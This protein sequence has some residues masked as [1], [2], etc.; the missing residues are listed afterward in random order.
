[1]KKIIFALLVGSFWLLA[2]SVC[3]AAPASNGVYFEGNFGYGKVDEKLVPSGEIGWM[4][5]NDNTGFSWNADVGYKFSPSWAIE[6]G[7]NSL[8]NEKFSTNFFSEVAEGTDNYFID[9]AL[10][11]IIPF[12]S[13]LS[14]FAKAGAAYVN[15][16]LTPAPFVFV[17]HSGSNSGYSPLVGLGIGYAITPNFEITVQGNST[18]KTNNIPAM[19][20][21]TVGLTI[22]IDT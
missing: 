18:F 14:L 22:T 12:D 16:K 4:K 1:M 11:G 15:H 21:G 8:P 13:G 9:L 5:D 10:K 3:L 7:Y 20:Q 19:M 17:E 2:N 6:L